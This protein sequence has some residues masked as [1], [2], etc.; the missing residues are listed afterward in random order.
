VKAEGPVPLRTLPELCACVRSNIT[1]LVDRLEAAGLV[2]RTDDP[3]D[4]RQKRAE[5]TDAGRARYHAGVRVLRNTEEELFAGLTPDRRGILLELLR[6][7][8]T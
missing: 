6:S 3:D 7:L 2:L 8:R 5:V 1:Q 4:R